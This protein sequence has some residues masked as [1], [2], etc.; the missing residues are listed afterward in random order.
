MTE[1]LTRYITTNLRLNFFGT[2]IRQND[3]TGTATLN[4]P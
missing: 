1:A 4:L 3:L 2:I